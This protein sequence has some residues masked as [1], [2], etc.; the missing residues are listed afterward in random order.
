MDEAFGLIGEAGY[1]GLNMDVL[2]ARLDIA[3]TTLYQSYPSK[4]E[5]V[6][7]LTVHRISRA[8]DLL[9]PDHPEESALA[10]L[11]RVT[12]KLIEGRTGMLSPRAVG[13]PARLL[14]DPRCQEQ[15]RRVD[16]ILA[17]LIDRA[18]DDGDLASGLPTPALAR[19]LVTMLMGAYDDLFEQ[20]VC[21]PAEL[22]SGLRAML[23]RGPN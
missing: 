20:G 5:L 10:R 4:D 14:A 1:S 16:A 19:L 17:D 13:M 8:A 21:T 3:K 12:T 23:F 11:E 9:A 18:R 7:A 2:A 15:V 6:V 22:V